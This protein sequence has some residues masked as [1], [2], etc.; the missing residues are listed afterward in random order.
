MDPLTGSTPKCHGSAALVFLQGRFWVL[1]PRIWPP[2]SSGPC[3]WDILR[4]NEFS[5]LF[6]IIVFLVATKCPGRIRIHSSGLRSRR[7][8]SAR[9]IYGS[10]TLWRKN[11]NVVINTNYVSES[12]GSGVVT[13]SISP[14]AYTPFL[15]LTH[16]QL[17]N[18]DVRY[19]YHMRF[20]Y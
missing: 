5:N 15:Q 14:S 9:N 13:L 17:W 3:T 7:S 1:R 11:S 12:Y 2:G 4:F 16:H 6:D 18:G 19:R 20:T 10:G 8:R